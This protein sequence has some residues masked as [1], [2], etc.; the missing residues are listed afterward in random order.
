MIKVN[1]YKDLESDEAIHKF[2]MKMKKNTTDANAKAL[3]I[4]LR[5]RFYD[6]FHERVGILSKGKQILD[7]TPES[8]DIRFNIYVSDCSNY[9]K[10]TTGKEKKGP[11]L[12]I[13]IKNGKMEYVW[14][15]K[16]IKGTSDCPPAYVKAVTQMIKRD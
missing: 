12:V 2:A 11:L 4:D 6:I 16:D 8:L 3:L 7:E 5:S 10:G 1:L 13:N 15:D 14:N 9:L